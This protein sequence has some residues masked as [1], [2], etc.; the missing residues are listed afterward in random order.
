MGQVRDRISSDVAP[1][2]AT[3]TFALPLRAKLACKGPTPPVTRRTEGP[4]SGAVHAG[5]CG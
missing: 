1:L 4:M 2:G 5:R 3:I